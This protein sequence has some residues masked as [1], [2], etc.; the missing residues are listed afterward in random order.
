MLIHNVRYDEDENEIRRKN[1]DVG[2]S[3]TVLMKATMP[4]AIM[5]AMFAHNGSYGENE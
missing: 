4:T 3:A 2:L 5:M 1:Y